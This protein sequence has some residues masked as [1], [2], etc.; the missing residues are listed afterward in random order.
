MTC[1]SCLLSSLLSEL[2]CTTKAVI[3]QES[4]RSCLGTVSPRNTKWM[5][6]GT[7]EMRVTAAVR[8]WSPA[9]CKR[10]ARCLSCSPSSSP[11]LRL[12]ARPCTT[13]TPRRWIWKTVDVVSASS[14]SDSQ[15]ADLTQQEKLCALDLNT[16][17]AFYSSINAARILLLLT[18]T[19]REW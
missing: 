4:W 6:T 2:P 8:L 10:S 18:V 17:R 16:C 12:S 11:N 5:R 3:R 15:T 13:L 1:E 7:T 9:R 19:F 14:R